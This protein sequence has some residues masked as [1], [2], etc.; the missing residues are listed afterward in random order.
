[1]NLR[2]HGLMVDLLTH[3]SLSGLGWISDSEDSGF[4][5]KN[6]FNGRFITW[7]A[8][9]RLFP[10]QELTLNLGVI[11]ETE[12]KIYYFFFSFMK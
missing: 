6:C 5:T 8:N 7:L 12:T 11:S 2:L 1:M 10:E 4:F 3:L 9:A